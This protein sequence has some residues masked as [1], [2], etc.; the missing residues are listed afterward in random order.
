MNLLPPPG[1]ARNRLLLMIA[2]LVIL[3]GAYYKWGGQPA[4][5]IPTSTGPQAT[6]APRLQAPPRA[7]AVTGRPLTAAKVDTSMPR[8]LK[9]AEMEQVPEEP[10]AGRNLFRFGVPPPPPQPKFVPPPPAPPPPPPVPQGP[11]PIPLKLA[12]IIQD[13]YTPGLNRA[14]LTDPKSGVMFEAVDG[15]VIDGRYRVIKVGLTSV[16]VAYVDGTGQRTINIG[17]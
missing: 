7:G 15:S 14:Y 2:A 13:P 12:T 17:G 4:L 6:V 16:V 8:P 5:V 10:K 11:P 1:P 3:G 9:L